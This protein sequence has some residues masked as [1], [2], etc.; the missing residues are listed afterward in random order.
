MYHKAGSCP[1]SGE[2]IPSHVHLLIIF[3]AVI[4]KL[5]EFHLVIAQQATNPE[6]V[7]C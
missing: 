1:F 4:N 5:N 3:E 7:V 2:F 6:N